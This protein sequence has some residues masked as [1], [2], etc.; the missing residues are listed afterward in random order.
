LE[1]IAHF[2]QVENTD[3]FLAQAARIHAPSSH[4][5][6]GA[7]LDDTIVEEAKALHSHLAALSSVY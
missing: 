1:R 6:G 5:I 2:I 7:L 4:D 3:A